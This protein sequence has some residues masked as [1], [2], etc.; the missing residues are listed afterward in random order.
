MTMRFG[1]TRG[2]RTLARR[3][4]PKTHP[5]GTGKVGGM[6]SV[7]VVDGVGGVSSAD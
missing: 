6:G 3:I 1:A 7:G 5:R 4:T 2:T